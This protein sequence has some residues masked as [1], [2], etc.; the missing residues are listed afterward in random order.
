VTASFV[1]VLALV[2]NQPA[3]HT[4]D[5]LALDL[6]LTNPGPPR[7]VDVYF[8]ALLPPTA[9]AGCP[10]RDPVMFLTGGFTASVVTCL[11]APVSS[12]PTLFRTTFPAAPATLVVPSFFRSVWPASAPAG[13]YTFFLAV[14]VPDAL[15]DGRLDP[16]DVFV[17]ATRT[18][19][20]SP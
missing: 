4:G 6:Q 11:S 14:T 2:A 10:A 5:T 16:G 8:G 12:F 7:L 19:T 9:S 18:V 3:F 1:H 13:A 20:F 15:V 17:L